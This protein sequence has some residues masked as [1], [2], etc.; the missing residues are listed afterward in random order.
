MPQ[1]LRQ[2]MLGA[3]AGLLHCAT[4][5]L[6]DRLHC[7][8]AWIPCITMYMDAVGLG[9]VG[10]A[11]CCTAGGLP[12]QR[13]KAVSAHQQWPPHPTTMP[14]PGN[15]ASAAPCE[16]GSLRAC[17]RRSQ[18]LPRRRHDSHK[19]SSN[20]PSA[21]LSMSLAYTLKDAACMSTLVKAAP[22]K[23]RGTCL[24]CAALRGFLTYRDTLPIRSDLTRLCLKSQEAVLSC[25]TALESACWLED[26]I[27]RLLWACRGHRLA[28]DALSCRVRR[29]VVEV[30]PRPTS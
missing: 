12:Q 15:P 19:T 11:Q 27:P 25:L 5:S 23:A 7:A 14:E 13:P 20:S 24:A 8:S 4:R 29:G 16:Q 17:H 9:T 26:L 1:K 6:G 28:L 22:G 2:G 3:G 30:R 18:H 10:W 21:S